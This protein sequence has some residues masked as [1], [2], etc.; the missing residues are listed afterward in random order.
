MGRDLTL[1]PKKAT[2]QDLKE[3]VES[4]GF[5]KCKHLWDWPKGTLNYSWF[6]YEDYRSTDGVSVDI[7][8]VSSEEN[9]YNDNKWALHVR[10]LYSASLYDVIMLNK[11]LRDARK[12]FGGTI[13]G[14]Y[15]TNQYAPLWE[16]TSTPISRGISKV[17][18]RVFQSMESIENALP[19]EKILTD[20]EEEDED[21][22]IR[23]TKSFD[24]TRFIYNGLVPFLVAMFEYFFSEIFQILLKYDK[25][26]KEKIHSYKQKIDFQLVLDVER[27]EKSIENIIAMNYTFQNMNQLNNAYKDWLDIDVKKILYKKKKLGNSVSFLENKISDIIQYRHGIVHHFQIDKNLRKKE[28][29]IMIKTIELCVIEFSQFLERKYSFKI[30]KEI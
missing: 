15:G 7:Y 2:K 21:D 14:D 28:F 18:R 13:H 29:K 5:V 27:K 16:D 25:R 10:N 11:V 17:Y 4:L 8:P 23:I 26:A 20:I 9:K 22:L 19:D 12:R 1:Y 30:E 24:P 6:E 3:F